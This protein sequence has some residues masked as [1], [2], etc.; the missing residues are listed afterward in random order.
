M[1]FDCGFGC[2]VAI[3]T[4]VSGSIP[5][6]LRERL[7]LEEQHLAVV[8]H[9]EESV[10]FGSRSVRKINT[11]LDCELPRLKNFPCQ[12]SLVT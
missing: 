8:T 6:S 10:A 5:N 2:A 4:S 1:R 11:L 9:P 12:V 3:C 7:W